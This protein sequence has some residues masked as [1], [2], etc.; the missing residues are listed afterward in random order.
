LK[1]AERVGRTGGTWLIMTGITMVS[2]R[3]L[4]GFLLLFLWLLGVKSA[5]ILGIPCCPHLEGLSQP[6][7][8]NDVKVPGLLL[9]EG[10]PLW[11]RRE[12]YHRAHVAHQN[13]TSSPLEALVLRDEC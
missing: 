4:G 9:L 6:Y 11:L 13:G 8:V 5:I 12:R 3:R 1:W 2:G 7:N 10:H